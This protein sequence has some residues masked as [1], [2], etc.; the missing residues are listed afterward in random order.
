MTKDPHIDLMESELNEL[1]VLRDINERQLNDLNALIELINSDLEVQTERYKGLL[2]DY[3]ETSDRN[4]DLEK[5]LYDIKKTLDFY[6]A[7]VKKLVDY[8]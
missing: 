3:T 1:R 4:H 5:E 7:I 6:E 8:K 2:D